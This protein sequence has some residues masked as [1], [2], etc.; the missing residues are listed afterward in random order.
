[1][2]L[3]KVG[4]YNSHTVPHSRRRH[5]SQSDLFPDISSRQCD[6]SRFS[7]FLENGLTDGGE[8]VSLSRWQPL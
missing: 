5:S 4:P 1:M 7:Y 6:I 8:V 3:L 2:F